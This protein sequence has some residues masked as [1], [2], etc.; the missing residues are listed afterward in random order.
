[1]FEVQEDLWELYGSLGDNE[2][3]AVTTNGDV[4]RL[5]RAVMGRGCAYEAAQKYPML[6]IELAGRLQSYG[7]H[8]HRFDNYNIFSFPVKHHWHETADLALIERS[9]LQL[10]DEINDRDIRHVFLPRPGV[11]NG[12]LRWQ[13]VKPVLMKF[14]AK[15]HRIVTVSKP[16][17]V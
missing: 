13:N 4:N 7:N 9:C 16:G 5:G 3:I 11:G 6:P 17:E 10:Q 1:M 15:D 14:F 8:V 2:F 12:K